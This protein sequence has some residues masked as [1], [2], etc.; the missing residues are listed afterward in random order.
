MRY[1]HVATADPAGLYLDQEFTRAY[2]RRRPLLQAYV[3]VI[4]VHRHA[5]ALAPSK[6]VFDHLVND[7][8]RSADDDNILFG[9]HLL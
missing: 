2:L 5:H 4:V 9:D 6:T 8:T 7:K 3:L 1:H